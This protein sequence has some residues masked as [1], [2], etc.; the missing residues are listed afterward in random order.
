MIDS[1]VIL[2]S[3]RVQVLASKLVVGESQGG[4]VICLGMGDEVRLWLGGNVMFVEGTVGGLKVSDL[5][6]N[7][8]IFANKLG[9][10]GEV[11]HCLEKERRTGLS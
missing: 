8:F 11:G 7:K 10:G 3:W 2:T 5:E 6:G 9:L 4:F 1:R